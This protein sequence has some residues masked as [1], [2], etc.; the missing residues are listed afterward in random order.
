M[1]I[2]AHVH[3]K[4]LKGHGCL[5]IILTSRGPHCASADGLCGPRKF[6][7]TG[8]TPVRTARMAVPRWVAARRARLRFPKIFVGRANFVARASRPCARPGWPYRVRLRL[9]RA[10]LSFPKIFAG[11]ANFVARAS[12]PCAR[13]GWPCHVGLRLRRARLRWVA[14]G[15]LRKAE[16]CHINA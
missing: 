1:V 13:P 8:G 7:G 10:R 3:Q 2:V 4:H 14:T 5:T 11:R 9:G 15:G 12:C 6:R 16:K